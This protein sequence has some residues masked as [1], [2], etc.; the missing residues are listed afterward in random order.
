MVKILTEIKKELPKDKIKSI[1]FEAANIVVYTNDRNYLFSGRLDIKNLVWKFKKRIELRIDK[2]LLICEE[3]SK[4]IITKLLPNIKISDFKFDTARSKLILEVDNVGEAIGVKGENLKKIQKE[5]FWSVLIKRS[6]SIKSKT[7]TA[8]RAVEFLETEYRRKFLD[9]VGNKIYGGW[10]EGKIKHWA[11][12]SML[13]SGNQ[14]GRSAIYLQ[15]PVSRILF[16]FGIDPTHSPNNANFFPMFD[17]PD[18]EF[19]DIDAIVL[20]HAHMD[21][22]GALPYL[23][24]LGYRGPIYCTEPTRD[25]MVLSQLDF[26][27]IM[28]SQKDTQQLYSVNDVKEMVKHIITLDYKEV[29]DITGDI[30][31]T[32]Y[33]SGH[34]LG[35]AFCHTNIGNGM[36]NFLYT[37]DFNYNYNQRLLNRANTEFPRIE[38]MLMENT[39]T[40]KDEYAESR[41]VMEEEFLKILIDSYVN[42]GKVLVPVFGVGRAQ[43]MMLTIENFIREGRLPEDFK[44]YIDGVVYEVCGIHTA[45]P[46]YLNNKLRNRILKGD[47]PF[48]CENFKGVENQ[49]RRQQIYE[50]QEHCVV[51]ATS[52]MLNG[53]T[54]LEYFKQFAPYE[55][56]GIVFVGY[57]A[58]GTLGRRVKNGEKEILLSNSG[59]ENDKIKVNMQVYHMKGAFSA[60]S[61]LGLS[62]KFLADLSVKPKKMLLNHGDIT[63]LNYFSTV[64]K[65]MIKNCKVYLPENLETVRLI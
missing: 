44:V 50:S 41:D 62:K 18:F 5:I 60:H 34:I 7:V 42:K 38:S 15:T 52:G 46:Q 3:E 58:N 9:K 23:Y 35:G 4:K 16:D 22:C 30:R 65:S 8:M 6:P 43:E 13:G 10:E 36:H 47:N 59:N 24:K 1:V 19:T 61:D 12:V 49:E 27:K 48:M 32:F 54:S 39:S 14:I 51:I 29:T 53:G 11:R 55:N 28:N 26:I 31:L 56:N 57:Q 37:G 17:S 25:L 20:S 63:K 45:Y 40:G 64:V 2:T 21:H 33:N